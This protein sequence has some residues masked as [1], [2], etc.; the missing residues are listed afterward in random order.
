M[1]QKATKSSNVDPRT[2][3]EKQVH[4]VKKIETNVKNKVDKKSANNNGESDSVKS[5]Q[6][7]NKKKTERVPE[8]PLN[9]YVSSYLRR[10]FKKFDLDKDNNLNPKEM[11][12]LIV[13]LTGRKISKAQTKLF[14]ESID[15]NNDALIQRGELE[16]FVTVGI[17]LSD[18]KRK[19]YA[20]RSKLHSIILRF[21]DVCKQELQ[22]ERDELHVDIKLSSSDEECENTHYSATKA[23]HSS[24]ESSEYDRH[25]VSDSESGTISTQYSIRV[26][27]VHSSAAS[28]SKMDYGGKENDDYL[29]NSS[30][31]Y[32]TRY[33]VYLESE[34]G[35]TGG[36]IDGSAYEFGS[37]KN[38]REDK[39]QLRDIFDDLDE[40]GD[41]QLQVKEFHKALF[42][43]PEIGT[44]I[45]PK[46]VRIAFA[47][48]GIPLGQSMSFSDFERF[49]L[50]TREKHHNALQSREALSWVQKLHSMFW[51]F[52][53]DR[54]GNLTIKRLR[55]GLLLSPSLG[56]VLN[57]DE[58]DHALE[59]LNLRRKDF[60]RF[61]RFKTF[62]LELASLKKISTAT[63]TLKLINELHSIFVSLDV[64]KSGTLEV[65][66]LRKAFFNRS[67]I[68]RYVTPAQMRE[69]F[70]SMSIP[71]NGCVTYEQFERC[72]LAANGG[73]A[74]ESD[75]VFDD[76]TSASNSVHG[77][78]KERHFGTNS[79]TT[80]SS[81][82]K[83]QLSD[84]SFSD[85]E[86]ETS[87][88]ANTQKDE[89]SEGFTIPFS[90]IALTGYH[91]GTS[92]K[93]ITQKRKHY[94][95][96]KKQEII[97]NKSNF[98]LD[99]FDMDTEDSMSVF[100]YQSSKAGK[101]RW[102]MQSHT[103]SDELYA[104]NAPDLLLIG[105]SSESEYN[106]DDYGYDLENQDMD[107]VP[108]DNT[109]EHVQDFELV[110]DED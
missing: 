2:G 75:A 44:Y 16:H 89:L 72:V 106:S 39:E 15:E 25:F 36:S 62:C 96:H 6:L 54:Y 104:H 18:M 110:E 95:H 20:K 50:Q 32:G 74:F 105:S 12:N 45:R 88:T 5:K 59:K 38:L 11:K 100:S 79:S 41:G 103:N 73:V 14:L 24:D 48:L 22:L 70:L 57:I 9:S 4:Y 102:S 81:G 42:R 82:T 90:A 40:D 34:I 17:N 3:K 60:V 97:D 31:E 21:F 77:S 23:E 86:S 94:G 43:R 68:A 92:H 7:N 64:N 84:S 27:S 63:K 28:S 47:V 99:G 80:S 51:R 101:S 91:E 10:L 19:N 108:G 37:I 71:S 8:N 76:L 46:D 85:E 69:T 53:A 83:N 78:T 93:S 26:G 13:H 66:E 109:G 33:S 56:R 29:S 1:G 107:Y 52:G 65:K 67:D 49:C 98:A 58:I 35:K 61:H 87:H 30:D 55:H